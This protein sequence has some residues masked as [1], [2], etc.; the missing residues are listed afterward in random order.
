MYVWRKCGKIKVKFFKW[1]ELGFLIKF[2]HVVLVQ[3]L[4]FFLRIIKFNVTIYLDLI[5]EASILLLRNYI[6]LRTLNE[7]VKIH[8]KIHCLC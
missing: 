4:L 5:E 1:G 8:G 2:K 3:T 7:V 6:Y